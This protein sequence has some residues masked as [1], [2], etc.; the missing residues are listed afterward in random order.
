M[1][2]HWSLAI[3]FNHKLPNAKPEHAK[4]EHC[5]NKTAQ[6][7]ISFIHTD[8]SSRELE[9]LRLMS[10][11]KSNP[12]IAVALHLSL[13]TVKTHVRSIFGKLGVEHR[14]QAAVIA[15]RHNLI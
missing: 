6:S 10:E 11:G 8:L 7:P 3:Y 12:Q 4:S 14:L 15:L 1:K 9:V 5:M 2:L 13:S